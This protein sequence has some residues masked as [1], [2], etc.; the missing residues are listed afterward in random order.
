MSHRR[1]GKA[2]RTTDGA[3]LPRHYEGKGVLQ[4]LLQASG[5]ELGAEAVAVRFGEVLARRGTPDEAIP[6]LWAGEPRFASPDLALR[7]YGN[8]FGLWDRLAAGLPAEPGA[9]ASEGQVA[10]RAPA[11]RPDPLG[12]GPLTEAFVE[13]AWRHL[14]DL[15]PRETERLAHRYENTQPDLFEFVRLEGG[16][17]AAVVD[18][19][20]TLVFE[21]W[22]MLEL[23]RPDPGRRALRSS[24]I[25]AAKKRSDAPEPALARYIDEALT[26]AELDD[27]RPLTPAQSGQVGLIARAAARALAGLAGVSPAP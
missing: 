8:L 7:A 6:S 23:A 17:D 24:E 9:V 11:P 19:A 4:A 13:S 2:P 25:E 14:A 27:E 18:N 15:S 22:A 21:L 12:E 1:N 3:H 16:E 5:S 26:E 10:E 20:D